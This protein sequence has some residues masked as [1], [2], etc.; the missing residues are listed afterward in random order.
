MFIM[1]FFEVGDFAGQPTCALSCVV[2]LSFTRSFILIDWFIFDVKR[3]YST[4]YQIERLYSDAI[5]IFYMLG[6][7]GCRPLPLGAK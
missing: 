1:V 3:Y 7:K 4:S 5:F 6:A 2:A